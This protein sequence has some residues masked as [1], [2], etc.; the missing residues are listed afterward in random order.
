[1][2]ANP[3]GRH[4]AGNYFQEF[5]LPPV[6]LPVLAT[7][8][9]AEISKRILKQGLNVYSGPF[10]LPAFSWFRGEGAALFSGAKTASD[11]CR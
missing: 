9:K 1:M 8:Y 5:I 10:F 11:W 6:K 7:F 2:E 3:S 4:F